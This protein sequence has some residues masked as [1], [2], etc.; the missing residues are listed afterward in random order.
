MV[1][2]VTFAFQSTNLP[3]E[4]LNPQGL[5]GQIIRF[6]LNP[7]IAGSQLGTLQGV[8]GIL[9]VFVSEHNVLNVCGI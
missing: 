4:K 3:A 1:G 2:V 5:K 6:L 8:N 7:L 9:L